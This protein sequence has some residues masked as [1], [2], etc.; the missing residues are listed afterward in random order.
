M[1]T[2]NPGDRIT[3]VGCKLKEFTAVIIS[4]DGSFCRAFSSACGPRT[5]MTCS[6]FP[7][8]KKKAMK[9]QTTIRSVSRMASRFL[10]K[11]RHEG[12]LPP[13]GLHG[14]QREEA[15]E[16]VMNE[17]DKAGASTY[18]RR[19]IVAKIGAIAVLV[20]GRESFRFLEDLAV[21]PTNN[22]GNDDVRMLSDAEVL[23]VPS[24]GRDFKTRHF[25]LKKMKSRIR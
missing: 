13:I 4:R 16:P 9:R 12:E 24:L 20:K 2:D 5:N 11:A 25:I 3:T 6:R 22:D 1:S 7:R 10:R 21:A 17:Y 19:E 14:R 23:M 15:G 18:A 8:Q